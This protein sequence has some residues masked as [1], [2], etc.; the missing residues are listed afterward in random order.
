[1]TDEIKLPPLP[2]YTL[3]GYREDALRDYARLAVEQDRDAALAARRAVGGPSGY[4]GDPQHSVLLRWTPERVWIESERNR[5]L[6]QKLR[7][8]IHYVDATTA[9]ELYAAAEAL[10][11]NER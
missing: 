3:R 11:G 1:M 4:G 2:H 8:M 9:E 5:E 10:A 6:A 7:K